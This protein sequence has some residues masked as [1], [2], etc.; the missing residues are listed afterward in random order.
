M[1]RPSNY[2]VVVVSILVLAVAVN[3]L[4]S[5]NQDVLNTS[6]AASVLST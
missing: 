5:I 3:Y 1:V 2:I 4:A 6:S